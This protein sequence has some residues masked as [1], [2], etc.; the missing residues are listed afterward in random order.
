MKTIFYPTML[1]FGLG[2][3]AQRDASTL[4]AAFGE[5]RTS[6]PTYGVFQVQFPLPEGA[7][8]E[9]GLEEFDVW[10]ESSTITRMMRKKQELISTVET[11]VKNSSQLRHFYG[12][13]PDGY[14]YIWKKANLAGGCLV[15]SNT[16]ID[17]GIQNGK[18]SYRKT[19]LL[20]EKEKFC[21]LYSS[22]VD[23]IIETGVFEE[24]VFLARVNIELDY[25]FY[26]YYQNQSTGLT[27]EEYVQNLIA[28]TSAMYRNQVD[29]A[30]LVSN[31]KIWQTADPWNETNFTDSLLAFRSYV[32][33]LPNHDAFIYTLISGNYGGGRAAA[34]TCPVISVNGFQNIVLRAATG[35]QTGEELMSKD[36][37]KLFAHELGHNIG[38]SEH[39]N[40]LAP[41]LPECPLSNYEPDIMMSNQFGSC[42]WHYYFHPIQR[43][44]IKQYLTRKS[45]LY[46]NCV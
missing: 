23:S 37:L 3:F 33:G 25:D 45:I 36:D 10:E 24:K 1:F 12:T 31:V 16:T 22:P 6:T 11:N 34:S 2:L 13:T 18:I 41:P 15:G 9:L 40:F 38:A 17:F 29:L 46:P 8:L 19:F 32:L 4:M 28:Y 21:G 35:I 14:V 7:N 20:N 27:I 5:N 30:L 44:I 42:F 26:Q 39:S 43:Y